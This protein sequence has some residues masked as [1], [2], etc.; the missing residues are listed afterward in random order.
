LVEHARL[1]GT[2]GRVVDA[3]CGSGILALSATKLG[4]ERVAGFDNDAEAVRVSLENA[5]LNELRG[6][7]DFYVGD[8]TTGLRGS[9]SDV[10]M[11]NILANVLIQFARQLVDS[12]APGGSLILSGILAEECDQVRTVFRDAAPGWK[13]ESRR[14]GEWSDVLLIRPS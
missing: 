9:P 12:V 8:L 1:E 13:Q 3:G 7:V 4:Y 14:L 2:R 5:E 11:A 10:V 6:R